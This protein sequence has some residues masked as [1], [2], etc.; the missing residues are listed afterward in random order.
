MNFFNNIYPYGGLKIFKNFF[1]MSFSIVH[2]ENTGAAW[3]ILASYTKFLFFLRICIVSFL[4]IYIF[5]LNKQKEKNIPFLFIITGAIGNILDF[6]FYGKVI[7]MFYFQIYKYSYP[8]FNFA[9]SMV[10]IGIFLLFLL[11]FK[12]SDRKESI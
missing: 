6:C 8:V 12:K 10:S 11:S 3:G 7:D 2:V 9:D 5:V 4:L 1:F